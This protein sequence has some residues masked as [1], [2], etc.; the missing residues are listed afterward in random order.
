[1]KYFNAIGNNSG[2]DT[3]RKCLSELIDDNVA[4]QFTFQGHKRLNK[5]KHC[6]KDLPIYNIL[7]S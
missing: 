7:K 4:N 1:M 5:K 2:H 3:M 6:F